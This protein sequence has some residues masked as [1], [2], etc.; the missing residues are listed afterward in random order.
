MVM[1]PQGA[2]KWIQLR[3]NLLIDFSLRMD[4]GINLHTMT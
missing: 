3:Q 2:L 1:I 4:M